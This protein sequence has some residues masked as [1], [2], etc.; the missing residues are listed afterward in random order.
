LR[1][2]NEQVCFLNFLARKCVTLRLDLYLKD[3][4]RQTLL[5]LRGRSV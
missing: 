3:V 5:R 4:L 1:F 2:V